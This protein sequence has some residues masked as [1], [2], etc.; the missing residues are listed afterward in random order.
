MASDERLVEILRR[1]GFLPIHP[2]NRDKKL[3]GYV[4]EQSLI[5]AKSI[6]EYFNSASYRRELDIMRDIYMG[7][8]IFLE[9]KMLDYTLH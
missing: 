2:K 7:D 5:V 3:E 4:K 6:S 9:M 1:N 8:M